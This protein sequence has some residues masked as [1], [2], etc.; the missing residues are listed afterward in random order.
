V[1]EREPEEGR[2]GDSER[3]GSLKQHKKANT[4]KSSNCGKVHT[5]PGSC[6]TRAYCNKRERVTCISI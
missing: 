5:A 3:K 1:R 6:S 4:G 2:E